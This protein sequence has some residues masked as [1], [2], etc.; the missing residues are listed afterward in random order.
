ML[1]EKNKQLTPDIGLTDANR[2]QLIKMLNTL[3]ADEHLLYVETRHAHWNITGW[4]FYA[5]HTLLEEQ[6]EALALQADIAAER[7]RMLGGRSTGTAKEFLQQSRLKEKQNNDMTAEQMIQ[8]LLD[9]H[10]QLIA[11][12]R[13]DTEAASEDHHDEGTADLF[14]NALRDHEKMAWMLRSTISPNP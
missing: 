4:Q 1:K 13:A 10:E 9:N 7:V 11:N 2:Q 14:I 8:Q 12:L 5:L 6:Y 3:L